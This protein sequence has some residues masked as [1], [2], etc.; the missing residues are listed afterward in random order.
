VG[1]FG[2]GRS[3]IPFL[4]CDKNGAAMIGTRLDIYDT[5]Y[6]AGGPQRVVDA[7]V[8]ALVETGRLGVQSTGVLTVVDQRPRHE[9][10]AAVLECL[11][12]RGRSNIHAVRAWLAQDPRVT[13]AG[14]R[15]ERAG[16]LWPSGI[17]RLLGGRGQLLSLTT[18]GRQTLR[19]LRSHPPMDAVAAGTSATRVALNGSGQMPDRE[20][21][22]AVF[23][24][25]SRGWPS[26]R[27]R[28]SRGTR[29]ADGANYSAAFWGGDGGGGWGGDF[30]G[31]GCDGG[32][33]G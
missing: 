20:L 12:S 31:G 16:L 32:S 23:A 2:G 7:A 18:A 21:R 15:L 10:E 9:I 11:V 17:R 33:G 29:G 30:G 1:P 27:C 13:A 8:V 6:L 25:P 22:K 5:A 24:A 4:N 3:Q 14:D 28:S 19:E 26:P